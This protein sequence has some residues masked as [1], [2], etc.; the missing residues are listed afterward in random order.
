[1]FKDVSR[2]NELMK[3]VRLDY[4][5]SLQSCFKASKKKRMWLKI[6]CIKLADIIILCCK[7]AATVG[8][9]GVATVIISPSDD[10]F[11]VISFT[12]DSLSAT[13][14]EAAGSQVA[15]NLQRTGG[16]LGLVKVLW[17]AT[18]PDVHDLVN[19]TGYQEFRTGQNHT[20][21]VIKVKDDV[22][23]L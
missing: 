9:G 18:G 17:S 7:L 16:V 11:G 10:A 12:S 3:C 13:L 8:A 23:R 5:Y 2:T 20:T 22:V 14:D 21:L 19:Y 15:L 6:Y 1:M 4:L